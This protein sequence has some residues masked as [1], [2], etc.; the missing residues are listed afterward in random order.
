MRVSA[1]YCNQCGHRNPTGA[2]FCS[3]CGAVLEHGRD[4]E[5]TTTITFLPVESAGEVAE[6]EVS[7]TIDEVPGTFGVNRRA[8]RVPQG[9]H[10]RSSCDGAA[11]SQSV[12]RCAIAVP[13]C[14]DPPSKSTRVTPS[15]AG[16]SSYVERSMRARPRSRQRSFQPP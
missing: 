9:G 14:P 7:V 12:H 1:V 8:N 15:T 11:I 5:T 16:P 10:A 6:E 3:S 13:S 2:N 4:E